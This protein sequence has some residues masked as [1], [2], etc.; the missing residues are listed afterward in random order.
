[1]VTTTTTITTPMRAFSDAER[2]VLNRVREAVRAVAPD[3]TVVLYG[4]RARGDH[5][6]D[7]DWDLLILLNGVVSEAYARAIADRLYAIAAFPDTLFS[8]LVWGRDAWEA[9]QFRAGPFHANVERD[10]V[11]LEPGLPSFGAE[12]RAA[13]RARGEGEADVSA[14]RDELVQ[15][16]IARAS[17]TL[18]EAD[19]MASI[20]AWNTC[21]NRL[22]YAC[23]YAASALLLRDG[24][25]TAKHTGVRSL[26][27]RAYVRAGVIEADLGDLYNRLFEQRTVADYDLRVRLHESDVRP[28][29]PEARRFVA[30]VAAL[31][32]SPAPPT[33]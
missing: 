33:T 2:A 26:L 31:L 13:R 19:A 18:V 4:S 12:R 8:P 15:L 17:E 5:G 23:F 10:G 11:L 30:T 6:P 27:N 20:G 32:R 3:A 24:H 22:Y 14:E 25:T 7:S 29:I 28:L 16:E 1:M 9:R 21:V